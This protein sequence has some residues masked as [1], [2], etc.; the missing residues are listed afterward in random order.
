[1][2]HSLKLKMQR[3]KTMYR[4][5]HNLGTLDPTLFYYQF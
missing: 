1:M 5:N 4:Y 2:K 3:N